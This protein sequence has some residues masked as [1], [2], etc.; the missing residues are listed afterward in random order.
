MFLTPCSAQTLGFATFNWSLV[1]TLVTPSKLR[2][3]LASDCQPR[4]AK[5]PVIPRSLTQPA[6]QTTTE[7]PPSRKR[8]SGHVSTSEY[9]RRLLELPDE[10][11]IALQ[12]LD[13]GTFGEC[14][15]CHRGIHGMRLAM[16]PTARFCSECENRTKA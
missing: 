14:E 8:V 4:T 3:G 9:R 5:F 15:S 10:I 12:K 11:P 13:A 7:P 1:P 6:P 2:S 16:N